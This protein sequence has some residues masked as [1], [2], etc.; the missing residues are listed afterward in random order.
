LV[1][2]KSLKFFDSFQGV[3]NFVQKEQLKSSNINP[4]LISQQK[5]ENIRKL[6]K[7][8]VQKEQ[9]KS[10]NINPVL[11]NPVLIG[12]GVILLVCILIVVILISLDPTY[13]K[14]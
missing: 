2:K 1:C 8:F 4:V 7:N 14:K 6:V 5:M 10:S 11:I 13:I 9:L 3:K 12:I